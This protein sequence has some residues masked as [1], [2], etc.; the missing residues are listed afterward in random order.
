METWQLHI[1]LIPGILIGLIFCYVPMAGLVLAFQSYTPGKGFFGSPW[2][3]LDVFRVMFNLPDIY[4][5]IRNT[6]IISLQKIFGTLL[7]AL[8]FALL[9][10]ELRVRF[11][12]R[13][14]Q[15]I[16]LFPFF[17]SWV[18]LGGI[19]VDILSNQG[20]VNSVLTLLG[21]EN[22]FFMGDNSWFRPVLLT[23]HIW[24]SFGYSMV[25]ILAAMAGIDPTLY[26]SAKIDGANRWQQ[27][28]HITIPGVTGMIILLLVLNL[29]FIMSAGFDQVFNMYNPVV[30]ETGDIIDTYVFRIGI[31]KA[32]YS[33][34][35]AVGL[36]KSLIGFILVSLS[37]LAAAKF[38]DYRIF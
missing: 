24:A 20:A 12:A 29:G 30:Y 11:I 7:F 2:V 1:K 21:I 35:T 9:I 5:V 17:L 6:V 15:T 26:E 22:V 3:G 18:V 28:L 32:Q 37:Y 14:F 31:Q 33:L 4:P 34:A 10:N 8:F 19:F 38:M 23:T 13:V 27:T 16:F 25:I 36:F